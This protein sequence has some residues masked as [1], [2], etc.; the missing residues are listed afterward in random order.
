MAS[1]TSFVI[2]HWSFVKANDQGQM[3]NDYSRIDTTISTRRLLSFV[4]LGT[5]S[6]YAWRPTFFMSIP[7]LVRYVATARA[8]AADRSRLSSHLSLVLL[9]GSRSV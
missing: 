9:I 8:R 7:W 6:P 2:G 1:M 4:A 3:T 5:V